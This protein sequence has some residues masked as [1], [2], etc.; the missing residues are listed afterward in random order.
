MLLFCAAIAIIWFLGGWI[1]VPV[2][3]RLGMIV[4]LYLGILVSH[5]ILQDNNTIRLAT[6]KTIGPWLVL[7]AISATLV[8]YLFAL[9]F[10]RRLAKEKTKFPKI[11]LGGREHF[12]NF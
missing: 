5:L 8:L 9:K 4:L 10:L 6:G 11:R 12:Q 3:L 1:G 7:G 2:K